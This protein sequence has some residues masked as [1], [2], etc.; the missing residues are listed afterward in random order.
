MGHFYKL[1]TISLTLLLF[2]FQA[3]AQCTYNLQLD[4]TFGD[5]WNGGNLQ[6]TI[7]GV[8]NTYTLPTGSTQTIPLTVNNGDTIVLT[9]LGG[10]TFNGECS[11][12]LFDA[13]GAQLY[14]SGNGPF[15]GIHFTTVA[16][17]PT[18]P[19]PLGLTA[20]SVTSNSASLSWTAGGSPIGFQIE[21]GP[22]G[23]A[24]GTGT[25]VNTTS[26]PYSLT[27]LTDATGYDFYVRS[28]CTVG[29]TSTWAGPVL[30]TTLLGPLNCTTGGASIIFSE[31]FE[32]SLP[33]TWSTVSTVTPRWTWDGAGSTP[34]SGTG[35]TGAFS[36]SGFMFLET[37]GGTVGATDELISPPIDLTNVNAPARLLFYYHMHGG[38]IG[39]LSV[40][41]STN[42]GTTWTT[43]FSVT[44][45]QQAA[46]ADPWQITSV[47]LTSYVG[48]N[49]LVRFVASKGGSSFEGDISLDLVEV[50]ACVSCPAPNSLA[51]N[52]VTSG[53]ADISWVEP[54]SA[55][56][57]Q[58]EYGPSGFTPGTGT[59]VTTTTI[60]TTITG[61]SNPV[62]YDFYVRSVCGAGDTSIWTGPGPSFT[63]PLGPLTCTVGFTSLIYQEDFE[64]GFPAG[65][66]N[67]NGTTTPNWRYNTGTTSSG[68][69][70]PSGAFSGTGY[71]YLE[72]SGGTT[73][74]TDYLIS[75]AI[76]LTSVTGGAARMTFYYHMYGAAMGS[77]QVEVSTNGGT[78][79]NTELTITGQQN[80]SSADPW[81]IT[82]VNL[83]A[84]I[85]QI[86]L[87]RFAGIRGTSFTSDM[88]VDLFTVEGCVTCPTPTN[89]NATNI[90]ATSADLNWTENGSATTWEVEYGPAGFAIGTGTI[91]QTTTNP[92]SVTGLTDNTD[93]EFYVRAICAP[94]D[95]SSR[96]PVGVFSTPCLPFLG[97]NS[98]TPIVIPSNS[99]NFSDAQNT[100]NGCFTDVIGNASEDAW[101][102]FT[103]TD[104]CA[105]EISVTL[106]GSTY[107]TYLRIYNQSLVQQAF[108]DD[109][110]GLQSSINNFSVS[111]GD[112]LYI[113]VEGFGSG[114]G[115]YSL[116]FTQTVDTTVADIAYAGPILCENDL[117]AVPTNDGTTGGTFSELNGNPNLL[118][119]PTTGEIDLV[120][121]PL[122]SYDVIY[123]VALAGVP[124]C[125]DADTFS[126]T[127]AT[128]DTADISIAG[129][130][131]CQGLGQTVNPT[132][133]A[134]TGGFYFSPSILLDIDSTSGVVNIDNS[135][136]GTFAIIYQTNANG[137]IDRDTQVININVQ[138]TASFSYPQ[139][140]LCMDG[141]AILPTNT[142][143]NGGYYG[144]TPAGLML[145]PVTGEIDPTMSTI[146]TYTVDFTT[147]GNCSDSQTET[148]TVNID[149]D[150]GFGYPNSTYCQN[151]TNPTPTI[152]G[153]AGGTFSSPT[154]A[155][156][157]PATGEIDLA[158]SNLSTGH[159][160]SYTSNGPC[161]TTTTVTISIVSSN[162]T[163][164]GVVSSDELSNAYSL[165][166]NPNHGQFTIEMD[167]EATDATIMVY[168]AIGQKVFEQNRFM[169][170]T[171]STQLQL[172]DLSSGSYMVHIT[173][174]KQTT[175][176]KMVVTQQ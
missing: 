72:T 132:I 146:G 15:N 42:G 128:F 129:M 131:Y 66:S 101:Y 116:N 22:A 173:D 96:S 73:G 6:V 148:I 80:T 30:F 47:D 115:N 20:G 160:I 152:T 134:A 168:N 62:M 41:V 40:D 135:P 111:Q 124:T 97:D 136:L 58:I 164:T 67:T 64:G 137:C 109:D 99:V 63:T 147:S 118:I 34:S 8:N 44:G 84:Y 61:L 29:D 75:P 86:I 157:D 35:P 12:T 88:S 138:D 39:T 45:Q 33:A 106:C 21:Y 140:S 139:V 108:N 105:T 68:S 82:S 13:G 79:W 52:N 32:G 155:I 154:G 156:V 158:A 98:S 141:A 11:F 78:T 85:G 102:E 2:A 174:A 125:V 48:N 83:N 77:L 122:G 59:V 55:T 104:P 71:M 9:W 57:W 120:G 107:D 38:D 113:V 90:T 37:S 133:N 28:I 74:S 76:D 50:E 18:C 123:N 54:G 170:P 95:T 56:T 103:V 25:I 151:G 119:N 24:Q 112:V 144:V 70:G 14:A 153:L 126:F 145:D 117:I 46:Q 169:S 43:E 16:V 7:A 166:P 51:A 100:G 92:L 65:W 175:V 10:S 110:C 171:A 149:D 130:Q 60:P 150:S 87:V 167:G 165:Y 159:Q 19:A 114:N 49:I 69:T 1:L 121:T 36:G 176:I 162:C 31:D 127:I 172:G 163:T 142:S 3:N 23:F 81:T 5:G 53:S 26:N 4:D 94:G 91:V 89:A 17:C 143:T 27:G 161:P 93:Y